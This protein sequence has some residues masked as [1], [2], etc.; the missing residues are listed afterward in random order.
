MGDSQRRT[1]LRRP[2]RPSRSRS[3]SAYY[4]GCCLVVCLYITATNTTLT[5][6]FQVRP[7]PA[8]SA[9]S[10]SIWRQRYRDLAMAA[11]PMEKDAP[12]PRTWVQRPD[13]P[14]KPKNEQQQSQQHPKQ[15]QQRRRQKMQPMPVTGYDA[16]AIEKYY[17]V[18][19]LKVIWRLNSI[20]LPLLGTQ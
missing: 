13:W 3:A 8:S 1:Q 20:G 2:K 17:D 9:S 7:N 19:P 6:C 15:P 12:P 18:R 5:L 4:F 11:N 14:P 10:S 16:S